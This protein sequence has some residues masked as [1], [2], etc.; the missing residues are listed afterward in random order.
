MN[1]RSAIDLRSDTITQPTPGMRAAMANAEV[2]DDVFGDDPTVQRLEARVAERLGKS[3]ALFMPSGTMANQLAVRAHTESGDEV[4]IDANAHICR[5]P[6]ATRE[7]TGA[8]AGA[9]WRSHAG[10]RPHQ[11]PRGNEPDGI[12]GADT[13][14]L[15]NRRQGHAD[16]FAT[17]RTSLLA[18]IALPSCAFAAPDDVPDPYGIL[19]KPVPDKTVVLTFDDGVA[20]HATQVAP[21]LK[22][23]GFGGSFY[24]CDFDSFNTRKEYYMTWPQ[25]KALAADGFDVGNH[26][27][28]HG[29]A[30]LDP[31]LGMEA[32]FSAN[33][34]PS[35]LSELKHNL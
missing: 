22:K 2:G 34:V 17:M 18:A 32:E 33:N 27:K 15:G 7:G 29:G 26:T 23:L 9:G 31:W 8:E 30:S 35:A 6:N 3:A 14:D 24:I 25:I 19:H 16:L 21:L 1:D 4:L 20:S 13:E 5:C 11:Y 10:Y 28:G 12:S